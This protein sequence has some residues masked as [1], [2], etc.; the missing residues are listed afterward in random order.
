LVPRTS[1]GFSATGALT[2]Q[3][4]IDEERA[5]LTPA[6]AADSARLRELWQELDQRAEHFL[7]DAGFAPADIQR[8]YQVNLRYP[9]QN[10]SLTV[11]A[12]EVSGPCD[13]AFADAA[14]PQRMAERFHQLHFEEYGHA[15]EGESPEI[16]GVRLVAS[17]PI[18]APDFRGGWT[19][20]EMAAKPYRQRRAN[21]GEGFRDTDIYHGPDLAPGHRV[22]GPAIIEETFTTIVI[23]PGWYALLDDAGD[24]ELRRA[25]Q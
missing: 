16:T 20:D 18:P 25:R 11:D 12:A 7:Q 6:N 5:C 3:P 4:S 17:A 15:R 1:P 2:A 8:R 19:A 23:Y 21:L 13:L 9:G 22:T 24:Y 14:L 10:W